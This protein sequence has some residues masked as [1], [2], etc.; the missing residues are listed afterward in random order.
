MQEEFPP[1]DHCFAA[2]VVLEEWL[3]RGD[4]ALLKMNLGIIFSFLKSFTNKKKASNIFF[5]NLRSQHI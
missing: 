2:L 1:E 5:S 4:G 3:S